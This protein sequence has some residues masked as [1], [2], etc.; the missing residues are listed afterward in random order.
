MSS[1]HLCPYHTDVE[2]PDISLLPAMAPM[3]YPSGNMNANSSVYK[4]DTMPPRIVIKGRGVGDKAMFECPQGS[5]IVRGAPY[6]V[7]QTNAKWSE[8]VPLCQGSFSFYTPVYIDFMVYADDYKQNF[9]LALRLIALHILQKWNALV[10]HLR[11]MGM[12]LR[13][14][15]TSQEVWLILNVTKGTKWRVRR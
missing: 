7:C 5:K 3:G 15:H 6:A 8:P 9:D 1:C 13:L 12:L 11:K 4:N 14:V 10:H 2:C